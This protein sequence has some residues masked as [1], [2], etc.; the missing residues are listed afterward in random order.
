MRNS[1]ILV[2]KPEGKIPFRNLD[3]MIM[4]QEVMGR[5][6]RLHSFDKAGNAWKAKKLGGYTDTQTAR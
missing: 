5:T 2:R 6:N 3:E 4:L 1:L